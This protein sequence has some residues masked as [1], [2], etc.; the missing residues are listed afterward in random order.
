L[1]FLVSWWFN[2]RFGNQLNPTTS[3]VE[4]LDQFRGF[5]VSLMILVNILAGFDA[6]PAW[7]K[8]ATAPGSVNLPDFVIPS[9][10]FIMG[11]ALDISFIRSRVTRGTGR[12]VWRFIRRS[13]LLIG[14]GILGSLLLRHN[15]MSEWGV[16]ETL[17]SAGLVALPFMFLAPD[18]RPVAAALPVL[19]YEAIAHF[20]FRG[21]LAAHDKG[22]LGGIPGGLAWTGIVL[23]GTYAGSLVRKGN[24]RGLRVYC[25]TLGMM[26]IAGGLVLS[27][28]IPLHKPTVTPSYLLL[29]TGAAAIAL[30]LFSVLDLHFLP[31]RVFGVNALAIFMLHGIVLVT[32]MTHVPASSPLPVAILVVAGV[33]GLCGLVAGLLYRYHVCIKL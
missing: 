30:L 2:L 6:V 24:T 25:A 13:L 32:V 31:L 23:L 28:S 20:G 19:G 27:R 4:F 18:W 16:L 10:L 3:R 5:T 33:Y 7:P 12:T 26:A 1:V 9:F 15:V 8:H 17:G 21:W 14:F 11:V 29:A 22:H